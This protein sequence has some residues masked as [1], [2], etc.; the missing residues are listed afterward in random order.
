MHNFL[1]LVLD[2]ALL[3]LNLPSDGGSC[4]CNFAASG[5]LRFLLSDLFI[6][7]NSALPLL[8]QALHILELLLLASII[9]LR[10]QL[11]LTRFFMLAHQ[12]GLLNLSF[13]DAAI[14]S[15]L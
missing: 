13:L 10:F 7:F 6:E 4:F 14:L 8:V 3:F 1:F 9:L 5:L 15:H 2:Y 11:G 12:Y